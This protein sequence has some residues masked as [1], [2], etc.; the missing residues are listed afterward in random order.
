[1][2]SYSFSNTDQGPPSDANGKT[3]NATC[4]SGGWICEQRWQVIDN[5]VAFH[6]AVKGTSVV[7]WYDNGNNHI[8]FGRNGKGYI[9]INDEDGAINGRSYHTNMP[10]G[11]YCDIIHGDYTG[12]SCTG[13]VITVDASG[14]FAA[15]IP[16]H[17]AV[18]IHIGAKIS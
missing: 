4:F 1:M 2:S 5:M 15:N 3:N 8:A 10:A 13:P 18:A 6:N 14:W 17:D 11:R 12:S 16:A 9:T 7:N